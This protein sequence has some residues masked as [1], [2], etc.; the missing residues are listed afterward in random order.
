MSEMV[1]KEK[2]SVLLNTNSKIRKIYVTGDRNTKGEFS[3]TSLT[4]VVDSNDTIRGLSLARLQSDIESLLDCKITMYE[5]SELDLDKTLKQ[6]IMQ[7]RALV[8]TR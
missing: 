2:L 6:K 7:T 8:I 3:K 1:C 5:L 4:V